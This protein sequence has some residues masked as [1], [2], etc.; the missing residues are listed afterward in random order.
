MVH[1]SSDA[2]PSRAA[3]H[4]RLR[5]STSAGVLVATC[6]VAAC[7]GTAAPQ[8]SASVATQAT[9]TSTTG[10]PASAAGSMILDARD[11]AR[12]RAGAVASLVPQCDKNLGY[13]PRPLAD[14]APEPHYTA[15][16]ANAPSESHQRLS[17]DSG[18]AYQQALCYL[19]TG[20]IRYAKVAQNIID[21]WATTLTSASTT[22][23][24]SEIAFD[25][26]P[27]T[28]AATWVRGANGWT[29]ARY[30]R[31]LTSVAIPATREVMA[32]QK[33]H[34]LWGT[35]FQASAAVY[36]GDRTLLAATR[37]R[38]QV[39]M[40]EEVAADGTMTAEIQRSDTSN[41]MGGPTKG[42]KGLAYTHYALL[43][44]SVSAKIFADQGMPV[45]SSA[46]G[47]LLGKAYA[48]A[49]GWTLRPQT[50]PYY[51]SN[52]GQLDGVRSAGYFSLLQKY[53]PS[54]D[55]AAVLA[56]GNLTG[57]PFRLLQ[58]FPVR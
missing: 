24:R 41:Y 10:A 19:T 47:V 1:P 22:S 13:V 28:A 42:K 57:D 50:F 2:G 58:L 7:S 23:G 4:G 35:L 49:A 36:L 34:G 26:T 39:L 11:L 31:F 14:L 48:K 18:M 27:M 52:H 20:K 43:P 12:V 32:H 46:G 37:A 5:P 40:K 38:W 25:M 45:W 56:Q 8:A 16:G 53:Y 29:G 9:S 21:A 17:A 3:R 30:G 54:K 55:G 6:L 33:N 44:A 51:A 15:T